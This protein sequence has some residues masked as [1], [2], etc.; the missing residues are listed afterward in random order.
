MKKLIILVVALLVLVNLGA[1][2]YRMGWLAKLPIPALAKLSSGPAV[3]AGPAGTPSTASAGAQASGGPAASAPAPSPS[4]SAPAAPAASPGSSAPP[5]GVGARGEPLFPPPPFDGN[6]AALDFGG[7]VE[8]WTTATNESPDHQ[9]LLDGNKESN[10]ADLGGLKHTAPGEVVLSFFAREPML[11]D[12]VVLVAP[13]ATNGGVLDR[14]P[15]DVEI[16]VSN[17][18]SPDDPF[19]RVATAAL[20]RTPEYGEATIS[21]P[22]TEAK[23][24]RFRALSNQIG[25]QDFLVAELKVMEAKRPGYTPLLTRHPELLWPG[26]PNKPGPAAAPAGAP[27][28]APACT[29][30]PPPAA[31][32][33]HP[34]SQRV[35]LLGES[36]TVHL[37]GPMLG[38]GSYPREARDAAVRRVQFSLQQ[39][40][41]EAVNDDV[42]ND[43]KGVL[44]RATFRFV[45]PRQARPAVLAPAFGFDTLV[46]GQMCNSNQRMNAVRPAFKQAL[47]AWVAAGH[48]LII[49]DSDDCVP[50]PD[51]SFVPFVFKTDTPGARGA[52]G[53][54]LRFLEDNQILQSRPGR[55]AYLDVDAW[56]QGKRNY[57]NE[58][59]DANTFVKW[60]ANWCGQL[61]VKNVNNVTGFALA[62]AHYGR[63][64]IIYD[65][66]DNDQILNRGYDQ[67]AIRELGVGFDPDNLPCGARLGDFVI[68]TETALLRRA[69]LPGQI[70]KYP[71]MLLSNQGYT[72][73]VSLS[74]S[75]VGGVTGLNARFEPASVALN[76]EGASGLTVTLPPSLQ[77]PTFALEVKGTDAAG[78]TSSL[79]LQ[80]AP[81]TTGDL[82]VVSSIAPASRTRKNVEIILD[83]S[84]SMKTPLAGKKSRWDV[85]LET[86]DEVLDGLPND[87]NVGLRMYGHREASTSPKTCTD[88]QLLVPVR[89]LDRTAILRAAKRFKPKGETPLVYS[90]LQSPAD[91]KAVGGG[92]VI[93]ITDGEESCKGDPVKAA[94]DLKASG[95]DIRLNIVGFALKKN[96]KVQKDLAGFAQATGGL[97]YA[98]ESGSALGEA[99]MLAAIEKLP[100][101]VYDS[102]GKPVSSGEAGSGSDQLP[103]GEYKVVVKAG[104]RE[105]VAPKVALAA[106]QS[107]TL[108][109]A[110]KNG[111]LVLQ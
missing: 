3:P 92:T 68:A 103:P 58:L 75:P 83:A 10:W 94:E 34:E 81:P 36:R 6:V 45:A 14:F 21:F 38:R 71:L 59:G 43:E 97:F 64:L 102:A 25:A 111:Q 8:T 23:F 41:V 82:S 87:F 60:D 108:T 86:L 32:P 80:F 20:P 67:V 54:G 61:T 48:K 66:F 99:L 79:C 19:E 57:R 91:L 101:T 76:G 18:Q 27:G 44:S 30:A 93:L 107:V 84:G 40:D 12:R 62:Y 5:A 110:I 1:V 98:A 106:G 104:T 51:Y 24:L 55:P 33:A 109:V 16:S 78:K 96:A 100:Y 22:P 56:V 88:S 35:L 13:K 50:G 95:L 28:A 7:T 53:S 39:K 11:V 42:P 65:G 9:E 89:K 70:Y 31:P 49:Q 15:K 17:G 69:S 46:I 85:A 73:T 26:G 52:A 4:G 2:A 72:G 90:A 37:A 63:G 29:A 77:S 105:L 47:M 74:S